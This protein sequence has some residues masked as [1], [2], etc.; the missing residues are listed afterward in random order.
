MPA[1]LM[2]VIAS[3]VH[4]NSTAQDRE[5]YLKRQE[6]LGAQKNQKHEVYSCVHRITTGSMW[7]PQYDES[8]P[9]PALR[10]KC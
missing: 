10:G 6:Y 3:C 4:A 1:A 7:L 2:S 9:E 8:L 5:E